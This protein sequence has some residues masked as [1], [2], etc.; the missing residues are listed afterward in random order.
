[1]DASISEDQLK[2]LMTKIFKKEFEKQQK[3]PLNLISGTFDTTMT[4]IKEAQSDI[5]KLK[6]S[7]QHTEIVLGVKVAK[8]K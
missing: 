2:K 3:D 4:E 8:A 5:N 6:A 7:F 1:M